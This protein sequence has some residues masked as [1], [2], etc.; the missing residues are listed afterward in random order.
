MSHRESS[1]LS[2]DEQGN[3][4][5]LRFIATIILAF[6]SLVGANAKDRWGTT[7]VLDQVRNYALSVD[8]LQNVPT[9]FYS[10]QKSLITTDRRNFTLF[11]V[12]T[13]YSIARDKQRAFVME[14]YN[15]CDYSD[16]EHPHAK[17]LLDV[18]TIP[19]KRKVLR[20][21]AKYLS[22]T[23]YSET[24]IDGVILSPFHIHN[25][26][27]YKYKISFRSDD[28]VV[29][30]FSPRNNNTQL[31]K[32]KATIDATTGR[33]ID[34]AYD[35]EFDMVRFH[36]YLL[37]GENGQLS[38]FPQYCVVRSQFKFMGNV[39]RAVSSIY[40]GLSKKPSKEPTSIFEEQKLLEEV[41][42]VKLGKQEKEVLQA[43]YDQYRKEEAVN[44]TDTLPQ[45]K[46]VYKQIKDDVWDTVNENI[47]QKIDTN[48]G[49]NNRGS[50]RI[51]PI[52]NPLFLRYSRDKGITYKFDVRSSYMLTPNSDISARVKSS[53]SF[54]QRRLYMNIPLRWNYNLKR[55]GFFGIDINTGDRTFDS[56]LLEDVI[57]EQGDSVD[58]DKTKIDYFRDIN[59]IIHNS[60]DFSEKW[61]YDVGLSIHYRKAVNSPA[62]HYSDYDDYY[63]SSAP[64]LSLQYRP[65][66]WQGP[67]LTFKYERSFK[68]ILHSNMNYERWEF[69]CSYKKKLKRL[70]TFSTR[71]GT[72]FYTSRGSE[73]YFLDYTNFRENNIPNG[74]DDDWTGEFELLKSEWYNASQYYVRSNF[75]Y[76]SPLL[77][78]SRIPLLGRFIEME[79]IY[80]SAL[81]VKA[82]TPYME[83][84]YGV[85][86]RVLSMAAF[87]SN[88]RGKFE[89]FGCK[90]EFE[91]F[92]RW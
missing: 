47:F 13:M 22:P 89:G 59:L 73:K 64:V 84:G 8:T 82:L 75:T 19:H 46:S 68:G 69:D 38:L 87:V 18:N 55:N 25:R 54:K 43:Y 62:F 12:P 31:I 6:V 91:L 27:F 80:L 36:A 9:F 83:M 2:Y 49:D 78:V 10:Y 33:I 14:N 26:Y 65:S 35:G 39:L 90:F 40:L 76:E 44:A 1:C 77:V 86:T 58:W 79:R 23:V 34:V 50:I 74:W 51:S 7:Q 66:G 32:G 85:T 53:Y 24:L 71:L 15:L 67:A 61:T 3:V 48:F 17:R 28:V 70:R 20:P 88:T 29:L 57:Q 41:R 81:S 30:S 52:F 42:P 21:V 37:M 5:Y 11:V 56:K 16:R 45:K 4:E 60:Q 63:Q 72:G 92:R